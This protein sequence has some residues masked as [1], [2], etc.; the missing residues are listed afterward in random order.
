MLRNPDTADPGPADVYSLAKTLWALAAGQNFPPDGQIMPDVDMHSL[1][2]WLAGQ[3]S[4]AMQLILE[5]ATAND[6]AD[7]PSM[8]EFA[9]QLKEWSSAGPRREDRAARSLHE[10]YVHRLGESLST[11]L[12]MD[13]VAELDAS[14]KSMFDAA[15]KNIEQNTREEQRTAQEEA[16]TS[17]RAFLRERGMKGAL[18]IND[19]VWIGP[20]RD[21][22]DVVEAV[23]AQPIDQRD[24][25]LFLGWQVLMGRPLLWMNSVAL[26]GTLQLRGV[27]GCEPR[28]TEIARQQIRNHLLGFPDDGR[29]AAA[30][31]LQRALIRAT[32][33]TLGFVPVEARVQQIKDVLPIEAQVRYRPR[34]PLIMM[35][36]TTTIVS[37][38]LRETVWTVE[39]LTSAAEEAEAALE[40]VPIP[41]T[42]WEGP[43]GDPWLAS[44]ETTDPLIQCG[45]AILGHLDDGDDLVR[46]DPEALDVIKGLAENAGPTER[47]RASTVLERLDWA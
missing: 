33:R 7:R 36:L 10:Q 15:R 21:G 19:T 4:V 20:L 28:A 6:P 5:A 41:P 45:A 18:H 14:V 29:F 3:G 25:D 1:S 43:A 34:A 17:R 35:N 13:A 42:A 38:R 22:D 9:K 16:E 39:S 46:S 8:A 12:D 30:W 32:V 23:I 47:G 37:Q 24:A 44:W 11:S 31:R 27:E 40:A 2:Y 26:I